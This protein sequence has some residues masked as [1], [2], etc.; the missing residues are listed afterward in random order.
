[1]MPQK[2][3]KDVFQKGIDERNVKFLCKYLFDVD[4]TPK[5]EEIVRSIAFSEHPRI[6]ISCLTRYGKSYCVS[7]ALLIYIIFN[8]KKRIL[9]ISPTLDQTKILRDYISFF[10]T[11]HEIL[12]GMVDLQ[13]SGIDR[14]KSEV[15]RKRITFKNGCTMQIL[16]A[17]GKATRLMGHGGDL[18]VLDES[19]L[20]EYAVYR[21][22][23]SRM[24]GDNPNSTLVEIGNPWD[25]NNQMYAHW[26]SHKFHKIHIGWE[27]ALKEGRIDPVFVEEQR[28][29]CNPIEF[30]VLY[31]A[32]F[33]E[34]S[35]DALFKYKSV[36]H[37]QYEVLPNYT[38]HKRIISCDVADKGL[39]KTVIMWGYKTED[40]HYVVEGIFSEAKSDNMAIAWKII[41]L[42]DDFGADYI[43]VDAIGVGI[44]VLSRL[45]EELAQD[46]VMINACHFGEGV[47]AAGKETRPRRGDTLADRKSDSARKRFLNRKA[48]QYFR[49]ADLF[50]DNLIYIP[51]H[52]MLVN[53]LM[54]MKWELTTGGKNKIVDPEEKSPDFA[55]ALCYFTWN[56]E[57]GV[58]IDW[59]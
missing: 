34:E 49:L 24:L 46:K 27:D 38:P 8:E 15:S 31:E 43:N 47:G 58:I 53:E 18:I 14:L 22:K 30:T 55:D 13:L 28:L 33:P 3:I 9:L 39:D 40:D 12:S 20:I 51:K 29:E 26:I 36:K 50:Q 19:C 54:A 21:S 5:Q 16:S 25:R 57:S 56:V 10:I 41:D 4:I 32:L 7:M 35:S 37:S 45:R 52:Q 2:T 1:M 44:G 17:E 6:V 42:F 11:Q 23:I 59:G 48:E